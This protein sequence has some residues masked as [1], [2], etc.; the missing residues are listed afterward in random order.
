VKH[1][2]KKSVFYHLYPLGACGAP[3]VNDFISQPVNRLFRLTDWLPHII[4]LGCNAVYLGPVFESDF[5]GYD[6]ADYF[7][8]DRRLGTNDT[9]KNLS[10]A[11]HG[12]GLHLVL[13]TVFNHVGRNFWAFKDLQANGESS[14]YK[15]WFCGIDFTRRSVYGDGFYYDGWYD[16]YNLVK[17]NLT[18][19]EVKTYLFSVVEFW[20]RE[21]NIDGL[22]LD[23]AEIMD[24]QF[25]TELAAFCAKQ[26][27]D[28][29][30]MGEMIS[31]DY[32]ELANPGML[33]STTNY[34]AYKSLYSSHNHVNYFE[35]AHTLN[36]QS[37]IDGIYK[38][39]H[40]YTFAD[41]H[42]TSRITS[43]LL[44]K[45]HALPLYA[46]LFTMPGVPS[47]YYGS[48]WGIAGV[49]GAHDDIDLR[50]EVKE[51]PDLTECALFWYL[52][53]LA[54]IR[55]CHAALTEGSYKELFVSYH[56][57]V[58][59]RELD[60]ELCIIALNIAED[61]ESLVIECQG[62]SEA[63]FTDLL[64]VDYRTEIKD[65]S[66]KIADIPPCGA[67]VLVP[68]IPAVT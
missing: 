44:N 1:N 43:L 51:I 38:H 45:A 20:I 26:K 42:D 37:G 48:E 12:S 56:Q 2:I 64:D 7:T 4:K 50:P 22:R 25:L 16:A 36:R 13:D 3:A 19:P 28:L 61:H 63:L 33:D 68:L 6:T 57:F 40:L 65:G 14:G 9:L 32:N 58:Y 67:R 35:L 11:M 10:E 29:W 53:K 47:I 49:K 59:S 5:H 21:F 30:L 27:E 18:N 55:A 46:V 34:E 66:I 24:R 17:L 8:V 54:E 39:L 52:Q 60:N 31:G 15:D 62:R 41:N 23:V